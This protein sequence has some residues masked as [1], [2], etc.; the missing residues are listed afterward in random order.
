MAV[1]DSVR[2]CMIRKRILSLLIV[3]ILLL[4]ALS[5]CRKTPGSDETAQTA[6][7]Q[8]ETAAEKTNP[9]TT[10]ETSSSPSD[11]TETGSETSEASVSEESAANQDACTVVL[12]QYANLF[13]V[14]SEQGANFREAPNTDARILG[15]LPRNSGGELLDTEGEWLHVRSS[16]VE[17]YLYAPLAATGEEAQSLAPSAALH[18]A[19]VTAEAANI[20]DAAS[21]ESGVIGSAMLGEQLEVVGEEGDFFIVSWNGTNAYL[22]KTV[23][24]EEYLLREAEI[25]PEDQTEEAS[26]SEDESDVS[27]TPQETQP[28]KTDQVYEAA[29]NSDS[30]PQAVIPGSN[31]LTVCIDA[32][33][34]Q[35]G[36][37]EQEPNGPGASV[38]KAKLTTGTSGCA[39]GIPEYQTTL[40]VALQL[41]NELVARGYSVVMIRTTNDCPVSNAERA[42]IANEY[43]SSCFI[44]I[45]CNSVTDP[46]VTGVISYAPA[47]GNPYMDAGNVQN[48]INFSTI[49]TAKTAEAT[50]AQNRGVIQDN[51]MTGIN[52]CKVPVTII[53]MGFSSNPT[54]DQ[55]MNDPS[56]QA[57]LVQGM[58]NGI[59]GYFGR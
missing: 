47:P 39:T 59:D 8:E 58:A 54:E 27:D 20:R 32:G 36:M 49:V 14:T 19:R 31:G 15:F 34:Q 30:A 53:E 11:A 6:S 37:P 25:L 52:W 16:C 35:A 56:Y 2:N 21:L 45:H 51:S 1:V 46:N 48:S 43:G 10:E 42:V 50:G 12:S 33:H 22:S 57:L 9:E 4:P 38:M 17:G 3:L 40:A 13:I 7:L 28:P 23:C 26:E 24:A 41:Q 5:A 29:M 18:F 44:R 55:L